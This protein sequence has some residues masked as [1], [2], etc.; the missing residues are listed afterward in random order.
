M[1]PTR[2]ARIGRRVLKSA[3]GLAKNHKL[4]EYVPSQEL[5]RAATGC[6]ECPNY[7]NIDF[8]EYMPDEIKDAAVAKCNSCPKV[9]YATT[10]EEKIQY[11]N[12]KNRCG[13][14]QSLKTVPFK[15]LLLLHFLDPDNQTGIIKN[16]LPRDL[17][18]MIG[19]SVRSIYNARLTLTE[20]GYIRWSHC[21]T[22]RINVH[23]LQYEEYSNTKEEHG[24]GYITLN[25]DMLHELLNIRSLVQLRILA[26]TLMDIDLD[27]DP[28]TP[29]V[30]EKPILDLRL[31]LPQY[32]RPNVIKKALAK[33]SDAFDIVINDRETIIFKLKESLHGRRTFEAAIDTYTN[34]FA[35]YIV[36]LNN[37]IKL[38]N[39]ATA[40]HRILPLEQVDYIN[41]AGLK[42]TLDKG[43]YAPIPAE[44]SDFKDLGILATKYSVDLVQKALAYVYNKY[45][46]VRKPKDPIGSLLR[47]T[48]KDYRAI[49]SVI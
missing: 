25:S 27:R 48:I 12:E 8:Y 43:F 22:N 17:A 28:N 24:Q 39:Q 49:L 29:P 42:A 34:T 13:D 4:I 40:E 30:V 23:L 6:F 35:D 11:V 7:K 37:S 15:L 38:A 5:D 19:C 26:R 32:C 44:P 14:L 47:N 2:Y 46:R 21:D 3:T 31:F 9:I 18:D 33:V 36:S 1:Q 16:I 10:Y 41:A 45:I 20:G